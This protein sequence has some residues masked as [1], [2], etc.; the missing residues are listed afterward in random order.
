M[1]RISP[2]KQSFRRI[3]AARRASTSSDAISAAWEGQQDAAQHRYHHRSMWTI[4]RLTFPSFLIDCR[5]THS[6]AADASIM[7]ARSSRWRYRG[8]GDGPHRKQA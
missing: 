1:A 3:V 4:D 5:G 8:H 6:L 7:P 2:F